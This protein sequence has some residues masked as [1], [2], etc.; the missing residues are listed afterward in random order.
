LEDRRYVNSRENQK[1]SFDL[2]CKL[3]QQQRRLN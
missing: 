3:A 2:H 1:D